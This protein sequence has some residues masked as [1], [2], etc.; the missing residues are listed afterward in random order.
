M[1]GSLLSSTT[2]EWDVDNIWMPSL[3]PEVWLPED[4]IESSREPDIT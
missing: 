1:D 3:G 2:F 4:L